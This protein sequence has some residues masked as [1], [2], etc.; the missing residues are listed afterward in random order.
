MYCRKNVL[1]VSA[2][3]C[4]TSLSFANECTTEISGS[5]VAQTQAVFSQTPQCD[6]IESVTPGLPWATRI[7]CDTISGN[8]DTLTCPTTVA[9]GADIADGIATRFTAYNINYVSEDFGWRNCLYQEQINPCANG[10]LEGDACVIRE[11]CASEQKFCSVP[12]EEYSATGTWPPGVLGNNARAACTGESWI[13][14]SPF[15]TELSYDRV[16]CS[17]VTAD[18]NTGT[19]PVGSRAV[20]TTQYPKLNCAVHVNLGRCRSGDW[21]GSS[22]EKVGP[23][24][25]GSKTQEECPVTRVGNPIDFRD[26]TKYESMTDYSGGGAFP[27]SVTRH[28]NSTAL[29]GQWWRFSY[30]NTNTR[31]LKFPLG[32]STADTVWVVS[33]DQ[34]SIA[35]TSADGVNYVSDSDVITLLER[36]AGGWRIVD[37]NDHIEEFDES[38][39]VTLVRQRN[40]LSH[41]YRYDGSS[42]A[43]TDNFGRVL[44]V[45]LNEAGNPSSIT[46]PDATSINYTYNNNDLLELVTYADSSTKRY[47]YEGSPGLLTGVTD[48]K[49]VRYATFGYDSTGKA[50]FSEHAGGVDRYSVLYQDLS[51]TVTN[52]LGKA[53]EHRF[54]EIQGSPKLTASD[55]FNSPFCGPAASSY[56]YDLNGF[57]S[58]RTDWEGNVT[59]YVKDAR[60][61][62]ASTIYATGT[63]DERVVTTQWHSE[64]RIP[65]VITEPG[66]QQTFTFSPYD[67]PNYTQRSI[68]DLNTG[69]SR[70]WFYS[71]NQYGQLL[72]V[73]G[74]RDDVTD[75]TTYT[76][77]DC[78][79]G[80]RCG[81]IHTLTNGLNHVTTYNSYDAHGYP[82]QITDANGVMTTLAY[83]QR[84]RPASVTIDGETTTLT[85]EPTGNVRRITLADGTYTE[86]V[87]DDANRL[88]ALFDGQGNRIDWALDNAGNHTSE[89]IKD[90]DGQIRKSLQ[91]QYD[92]LSRVR[93]MIYSHGG[94]SPYVYDNNGNQTG[95]TDAGNRIGSSQYDALNRVIK[96][97]D[98]IAGETIYTYDDR[99]NL[100]TVTDPEGL[101]TTY[102]Y[103]GF[104]EVII[105][106]SPDTGTTIYTYDSAGNRL[107]QTDARGTKATYTYDALNRLV[108]VSYPD[109]SENIV[110]A[111]D[112]GANG[113]GRLT[114]ITDVS[115][116]TDYGYDARGNTTSVTQTV[117]DQSYT[118]TYSYNG[119]NRLTGMTYPSGRAV[120]YQYDTSGR[121]NQI[122][123]I[124]NE[125]AETLADTIVRL[126]FGPVSSLTLGNG[127][128]R[129]RIY[130]QDYRAENLTDG[131][132]F[133]K[134]LAYSAVNNITAITD[135][136]DTNLSQL[137]TYDDLDRLDFATGNYGEDTYTYDGIGNRQS[138]SRDGQSESYQYGSGTHRL[139]SVAGQN[140]QYDA[141]GNTMSDGAKSYTYNNRNRLVSASANGITTDYQH[142]ALGQRVIKGRDSDQIH[143][144]YNLEG[145]LIAEAQN[146]TVTVE[147]AYLDGE[148]LVMWRD[149]ETPK[150]PDPIILLSPLETIT[151]ASPI[152]E[153][154]DEGTAHTYR[155]RIYDRSTLS[156]VHIENHA[157]S[158]IC[159]NGVCSVTPA[160]VTLGYSVNHRW[161]VRANNSEGW[162]DW[163]DNQLFDYIDAP[164]GEIT[165]IAPLVS[166]NMATPDYSWRDLG[167]VTDYRL[168]VYDRY[169]KTLVHNEIH[170]AN[171]ICTAGTCSVTPA[172]VSLNFS[173]NHF[174]RLRA[175]NSGGW[176][177]WSE[178]NWFDY[179]DAPPGEITPIAPLVSTDTATPVYSWQDLGNVTDYRLQIYDRLL[180]TQVHNEL[181]NAT[182]ICSAGSCSL[183]PEGVSLNFSTNHFWRVRARNSGGWSSW[184]EVYRFD[185]TDIAPGEVIPVSPAGVLSNTTPQHSWTG[186]SN[187]VE[188]QIVVYDR[189][190]RSV[191][192]N[193]RYP[194][195]D[196]CVNISCSV[197]PT[198]GVSEGSNHFWRVRAGNSGGWGPWSLNTA[199]DVVDG[200]Q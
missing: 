151:T 32:E 33:A 22:C 100:T 145:R 76:Y 103:N 155:L 87:R 138:F 149:A 152:F 84:Q 125:G 1:A 171:D 123:S 86:Y 21:T 78:T 35:F 65:E 187:A 105:E 102:T 2:L 5:F 74:P 111:Y 164:P 16:T 167:N 165:P 63:T 198:E 174:W 57:V 26:G 7:Y 178:P 53:T 79:T 190:L 110:Y 9:S 52:P 132:V 54:A 157:A 120:S 140:Y 8:P 14:Q 59:S 117:G 112:Q 113:V 139:Q 34:S 12:G 199:F 135:S 72:S 137:F 56:E 75:T 114:Q 40:G 173:T 81:Q 175:R 88:V 177:S 118:Q 153:W 131:T 82:T 24:S 89:N 172:D 3:L 109:N 29:A 41:E 85:Y 146:G 144:V 28:Y 169:L 49:G 147:Y 60:G 38:G 18:S 129:T 77:Y 91:T 128:E 130:D 136:I 36:L 67:N 163:T 108:E 64:Y 168:L 156:W 46:L 148:P 92:E 185:Y 106:Q 193:Q 116:S 83:D 25:A 184:S 107:T 166:T 162:N 180:R 70:T 47:H 13:V 192:S 93:G 115:G 73:D 10:E 11:Q 124:G 142:N 68:T 159:S 69:E 55:R 30:S 101:T 23:C 176:S 90:R 186:Q 170:A 31:S 97:I 98:A 17:N 197:T 62:P 189:V 181:H 58:G 96:D 80:G 150:V 44:I 122:S 95:Y 27:V 99:D 19:C 126:P 141:A 39:R 121:V 48:E 133:A 188:Y 200:E 160:D 191:A 45:N 66:R 4:L 6:G 194:A 37:K 161:A 42:V 51:S 71:Y 179:I 182:D 196:I 195:T 143:Y 119:A 15:T 94:T 43:V 134:G 154:E 158:E 104:D 50:I 61:L 183:T 20:G 127:I